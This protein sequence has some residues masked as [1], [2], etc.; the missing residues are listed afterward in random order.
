[1]AKWTPEE[2]LKLIAQYGVTNTFMVPTMFHRLLALPDEIRAAARVA[3]LTNVMH[4][5]APCPID[6]K[7]RM[8][9]WWGPV[10]Y[11]GYSATEGG[12]T[13]V[14]SHDWLAHPGTVGRPWPGS[15]I[16]IVREDGTAAAAG[17]PGLIYFKEGR[18][19]EYH[20]DPEKTAAVHRGDF[21]TVGDIGY[22][23][24]DGWLY[25]CDRRTDLIISGGVN[26]YPAEVE[27][28]LLTHPAVR[29]VAVI[30]VPDAEWGQQARAVVESAIGVTA[31]ATLAAELIAF[32]RANLAHYKCPRSV[33]FSPAL[34]RTDTGKLSR[35]QVRE[36]YA[37]P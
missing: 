35:A 32:C 28:T 30:G 18:T 26:I 31:D 25:I 14:S 21:F 4:G 1:M 22:L 5:G 15:E 7:R 16:K 9:A 27:G 29:D 13:T 20:R 6:V 19:F 12:G 3:T 36:R 34:P 24:A 33:V 2:T 17:E 11:E 37:A 8:I 23:D 10:L